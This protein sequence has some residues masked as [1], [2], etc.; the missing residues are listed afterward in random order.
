MKTQMKFQTSWIHH[1]HVRFKDVPCI[2]DNDL[3]QIC[4]VDTVHILLYTHLISKDQG[5]ELKCHLRAK[6]DLSIDFSGCEK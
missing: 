1:Q 4:I 2:C 5:P 6:E 3:G